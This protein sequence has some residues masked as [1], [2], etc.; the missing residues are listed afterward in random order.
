MDDIAST[1]DALDTPKLRMAKEIGISRSYFYDVVSGKRQPT[2]RVA[3]RFLS[4]LN[5]PD[6]LKRLKRRR[7]V[8]FEEVFGSGIEALPK[9]S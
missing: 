4:F 2:V 6:N 7:P 5:R 9:A 3:S 1:L 8:T